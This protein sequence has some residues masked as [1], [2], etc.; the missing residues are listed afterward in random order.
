MFTAA[1][2][3]ISAITGLIVAVQQLRPT[4][5]ASP[6]TSPA[7]TSAANTQAAISS[8]ATVA[9]GNAG[10]ARTTGARVSFSA[11]AHAQLGDYRYDFLSAAAT[12]GNPGEL[13]LAIRV[14]L[15]NGSRYDANFWNG[16]F[17]LRVGT[18]I[19]GPTNFLDDLVHG[20]TTGTAEIDFTVPA[21]THKA[22]LLVGDDPAHA[23]ALP[24]ALQAI[25]R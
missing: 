22:T 15:T 16:T 4:S 12:A 11:G 8:A 5:H 2:G 24:I 13:A 20:G 18:D 25:N 1:A 21:S 3:L 7:L 17:R 9:T 6:P 23:V 10:R 19:T 14:K